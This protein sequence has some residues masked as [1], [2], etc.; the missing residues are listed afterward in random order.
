M[1]E[2]DPIVLQLINYMKG[3]GVE[4]LRKAEWGDERG[5]HFYHKDSTPSIVF[6]NGDDIYNAINAAYRVEW[7]PHLIAKR[8]ERYLIDL[9]NKRKFNEENGL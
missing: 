8:F 9:H 1:W 4:M 5:I 6:V 3:R 2:N 7:D